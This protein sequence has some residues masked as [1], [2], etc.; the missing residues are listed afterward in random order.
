MRYALPRAALVRC[1]LTSLLPC[2]PQ[3]S[4][5]SSQ[6]YLEGFTCTC[7]AVHPQGRHFVAQSHGDY[8][9][10]FSASPPFRLNK[11]KV[12]VRA[13]LRVAALR[14]AAHTER[15]PSQRFEGHR[16]AGYSVRCSFSAD[17]GAM[18]ASGSS[19]GC[20]FVYDARTAR[21]LRRLR[22]HEAA[23]LDAAFHPALPSIVA[24]CSWD[25]DVCVFR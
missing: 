15:P 18:L 3:R 13:A 23:C 6:V 10:Q 12:G 22:A 19:D 24:S 2:T 8:I 20:L 11:Y 5:S 7:V 25:G 17:D 21:V 1:V 9:A 4:M 14:V 16:S